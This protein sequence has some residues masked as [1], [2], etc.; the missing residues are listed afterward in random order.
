MMLARVADSLYWLG[1]YIER[2]E[3]VSRL[4][5]VMLNANLDRTAAAAQIG[6]TGLTAL[7][8]DP[9]RAVQTYAAARALAL[10]REDT[11]SVVVS[12]ARARENA[13]QVRDQITTETWE[14]LNLLHLR[15]AAATAEAA[16][17]ADPP[18]FLG[19]II[20]D[21]HLFKGAADTT[22][23]HGEG[24]QFLLLGV[25]LER[26]QLIARLL[27]VCFSDG[28]TTAVTDPIALMGVLRMACALEPYLRVYT[29]D[30]D[31]R[32][33]LE[34][35]LFNEEFPRSIRFCT[36]RIQEHLTQLV[37]EAG[38]GRSKALRL[39][40]RLDARLKYADVEEVE[41]LGAGALLAAVAA[42]CSAIH[43]VT[44][45][46]FVAYPLELSLP[47]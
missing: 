17:D 14:R 6:R 41:R 21:L 34:F 37:R 27:E 35:L 47:A 3:H 28:R 15:I 16:F 8:A 12:L 4:S 39:A 30:I 9:G 10:D 23:S 7:G 2:A 32:F 29:A 26:A 31:P 40:G 22:L 13:R 24:W 19:E 1:R 20:A 11:G 42:E 36:A 33:I 38:A 46:T 45:E 43:D 44:Y 25:Y 5:A 18:G